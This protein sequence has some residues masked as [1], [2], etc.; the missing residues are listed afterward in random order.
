MRAALVLTVLAVGCVE[1]W[2]QPRPVR[3]AGVR[4]RDAGVRDAG[5]RGRDTGVRRDAGADV[6]MRP[7]THGTIDAQAARR[8]LATRNDAV[9]TCY[10]RELG[11]DAALRGEIV[12]E[13]TSGGDAALLRVG[14]CIEEALRTLRFPAPTGGAATVAAPFVFQQGT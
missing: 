7:P 2:A 14:R 8:V 11:H 6:V 3:D 5:V 9:R 4:P 12:S 1:A 10:E 13:T